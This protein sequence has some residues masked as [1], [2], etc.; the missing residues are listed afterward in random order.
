MDNSNKNE[1]IT[2]EQGASAKTGVALKKED[3]VSSDMPIKVNA[4]KHQQEAYQLA[5][6]TFTNNSTNSHGAGFAYLMEMGTGK[7]LSA[8]AVAGTLYNDKKIAR[9]LIVAPLS[10][11][12]VW[13]DELKKFADFPYSMVNLKDF[14][15]EKKI[16]M[17]N[18]LN[19]NG[20][21]IVAINYESCRTLTNEIS[22]WAPGMIIADEGHKI[23]NHKA[24]NSKSLHILGDNAA[25]KLLLTGTPITNNAVDIWSEYRFL[26]KNIFGSNFY[27]FRSKYFDMTGF[28]NH[29]PVMKPSMM[30]AYTGR[31]HSISYRA[32]KKDCLDLPETTD[33]IRTIELEP[34]AQKIYDDLVQKSYAELKDGTLNAR[35][36]LAQVLRL[37]Q[38]T[39]GFLCADNSSQVEQ[40][41]KAKL[42]CLSE[43][44]D[45]AIEEKQKLVV[46]CHYL[47]EID[48][49]CELLKTKKT[50]FSRL[51]GR[52]N[53]KDRDKEIKQFQDEQDV[54][55][56]VGQIATAG[57][58]INLT[59]AS[60][61]VFY[62]LDY[63][64]SNYDQAK[65]RIHR[66]GQEHPC[67]Y[68]H[69]I[70]KKTIDET[71]MRSLKDKKALA[72]VLIDDIH[73]GNNPFEI[74]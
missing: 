70:A 30:H 12:G 60:T 21:Q 47:S 51:D 14:S 15:R 4:Y 41:S 45:T 50:K 7:T 18:E 57:V 37:G 64:M 67:T 36:I 61:M 52:I 49:I 63:N 65:A 40:V 48:A 73:N 28:E 10:V 71:I 9:L 56:F 72:D 55:V 32:Q 42:N 1:E 2:I 59:A 54:S 58:G 39:G 44:V 6:D 69:F 24:Q 53:A 20:L 13:E 66:K 74:K 23:K 25:Y 19:G 62:S 29:T 11:L 38:L 43:L 3:K 22:A 17:L 46:F 8:I 33:S 16:K 35:N 26:D 31:I 27:S 34:K 68:I 5:L